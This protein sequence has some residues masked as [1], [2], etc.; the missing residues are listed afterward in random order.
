MHSR[1]ALIGLVLV[2]GCVS[3]SSAA[4][5][6]TY[7]VP[8]SMFDFDH[9]TWLF[10][11]SPVINN[12]VL[13]PVVPSTPT[14]PVFTGDIKISAFSAGEMF[15]IFG[16]TA[17]PGR[18]TVYQRGSLSPTAVGTVVSDQNGLFMAGPYTAGSGFYYISD[19]DKN[20][21]QISAPGS[22][23]ST[24]PV[25]V[26]SDNAPRISFS[27]TDRFPRVGSKIFVSGEVLDAY[28][29]PLRTAS[30]DLMISEDG[31]LTYDRFDTTR[32]DYRGW[33]RFD[34]TVWEPGTVALKTQ[35]RDRNNTAAA[36]SS[37]IWFTVK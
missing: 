27:T 29:E 12:P 9:I 1:L 6:Q 30:I 10:A 4:F 36:I 34:L 13:P 24:S 2:I 35:Y 32:T 16:H 23:E 5:P 26:P 31:G 17:N 19:G 28:S 7:Q 22:T 25:I 20:S 21:N 33:Y 37:P 14:P 15:Y 3:V 8:T 18:V 11:P